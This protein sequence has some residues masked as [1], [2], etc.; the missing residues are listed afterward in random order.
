MIGRLLCRLF[1]PAGYPIRGKYEC[2][3]CQRIWRVR[4]EI[5]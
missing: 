2:P 5:K 4:W 3:V 1:H